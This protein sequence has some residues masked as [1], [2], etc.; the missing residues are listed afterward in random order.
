MPYQVDLN[1]FNP[2]VPG[3]APRNSTVF[4][5]TDKFFTT[6]N[7]T[8]TGVA[9]V[10]GPYLSAG[11]SGSGAQAVNAAV[12]TLGGG[13]FSKG[14]IPPP[15]G[16]PWANNGGSMGNTGGGSIGGMGAGG[17]IQSQIDQM[18]TNN[19]SMLGF[20]QQI[21]NNSQQVQTISNVIKTS[22][23]ASINSIRN[24]KA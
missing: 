16:S 20:Q 6:L 23:D 5:G 18:Y 4:G 2:I 12:S 19:L 11:F 15:P 21:Q 8:M 17:D 24:F 10:A 9:Q 1:S 13:G 3:Q 22:F 7:N 14:M